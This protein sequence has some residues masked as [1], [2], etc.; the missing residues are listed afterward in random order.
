MASTEEGDM[1][2]INVVCTTEIGGNVSTHADNVKQGETTEYKVYSSR[3]MMLFV[4]CILNLSNAIVS[5]YFIR[6]SLS[7]YFSF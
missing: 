3:W 5:I 6:L 2:H 1:G 7:C 4:V